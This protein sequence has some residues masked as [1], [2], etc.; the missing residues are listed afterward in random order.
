MRVAPLLLGLLI[1]S[2]AG[3]SAAAP[4]PFLPSSR[5]PSTGV[6]RMVLREQR[7]DLPGHG[8]RFRFR[9]N[10]ENLTAST[11]PIPGGD[12]VLRPFDPMRPVVTLVFQFPDGTVIEDPCWVTR[13]D[14]SPP[15]THTAPKACLAFHLTPSDSGCLVAAFR[16]NKSRMAVTA[17]IGSRNWQSNT[18]LVGSCPLPHDKALRHTKYTEKWQKARD[19]EVK[20]HRD[21]MMRKSK[22]AAAKAKAREE[23]ILRAFRKLEERK[24]KKKD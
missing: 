13:A 23:A 21:E 17:V 24:P 5:S 10:W 15:T 1:C 6:V 11:Q 22:A 20:A 9:L 19:A 3:K 18:L 14:D 2:V 7:P 16:R 8:E 4:K 12:C